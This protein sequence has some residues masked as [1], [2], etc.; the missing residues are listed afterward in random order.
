MEGWLEEVPGRESN[1]AI[2]PCVKEAD[3]QEIDGE[4]V[5]KRGSGCDVYS[6]EDE[7]ELMT[8]AG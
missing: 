7:I 1:P 6:K 2:R 8:D 3:V 4:E 5:D